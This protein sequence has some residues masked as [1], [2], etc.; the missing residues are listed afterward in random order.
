VKTRS[1]NSILIIPGTII[2]FLV[3]ELVAIRLGWDMFAE[4]QLRSLLQ[5]QG[6]D[7]E[8][9]VIEVHEPPAR[10][11]STVKYQ[12]ASQ[13]GEVVYGYEGISGSDIE[14]FQPGTKIAIIYDPENPERSMLKYPPPDYSFVFNIPIV[15]VA[16]LGIV[17]FAGAGIRLLVIRR[18][19][20]KGR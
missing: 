17:A 11:G 6:I 9:V 3:L 15:A 2:G 14:R 18:R 4:W 10:G 12:F 16:L 5:K 20:S 8:A 7:T 1:A 19:W 13:Y